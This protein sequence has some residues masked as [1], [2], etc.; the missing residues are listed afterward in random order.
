MYEGQPVDEVLNHLKARKFLPESATENDLGKGMWRQYR[1]EA[2]HPHNLPPGPGVDN[3]RIG[4][5]SDRLRKLLD[6]G[7]ENFEKTDMTIR[8]PEL[9]RYLNINE[10]EGYRV[11]SYDELMGVFTQLIHDAPLHGV[12]GEYYQ[13][14]EAARPEVDFSFK[15]TDSTSDSNRIRNDE[16]ESDSQ[17][18]DVDPQQSHKRKNEDEDDNSNSR[19]KPKL[20]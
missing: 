4:R 1:E 18:M 10:T 9:L 14:L 2:D 13:S 15:K 8:D 6:M 3:Q 16:N 5:I 12:K 11:K 7:K 17:D 20:G 19:K